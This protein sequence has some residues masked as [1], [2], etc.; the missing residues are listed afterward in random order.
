MSNHFPEAIWPKRYA[1]ELLSPYSMGT[2]CIYD[3]TIKGGLPCLK[4]GPIGNFSY[5]NV[6]KYYFKYKIK[7][8]A[9]ER[10]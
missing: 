3:S 8:Y 4:N 10:V 7:L 9:L 5:P 6:S 1:Q 2:K